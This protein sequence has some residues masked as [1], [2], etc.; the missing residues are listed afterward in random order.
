M[1]KCN[2]M[3]NLIQQRNKEEVMTHLECCEFCK[4][5]YMFDSSYELLPLF[6]EIDKDEIYWAK[7]RN[8]IIS[9]IKKG[10][11]AVLVRWLKYAAVILLV[12][13]ITLMVEGPKERREYKGGEVAIKEHVEEEAKPIVEEVQNPGARLYKIELDKDTHLI[14]VVDSNIDL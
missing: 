7:H 12:V 1:A 5:K 8:A 4:Q 3:D 13:I 2:E 6:S 9:K 11:N 10:E 14:M